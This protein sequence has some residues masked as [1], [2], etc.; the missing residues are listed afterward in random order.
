MD[1][2]FDSMA[3][4]SL[5]VSENIMS[6]NFP[7]KKGTDMEI[8]DDTNNRHTAPKMKHNNLQT[9]IEI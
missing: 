8:A 7:M 3:A 4:W 2:K 9:K 1:F 5:L 6:I